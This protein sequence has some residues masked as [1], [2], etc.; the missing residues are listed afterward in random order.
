VAGI[1]GNRRLKMTLLGLVGVFVLGYGALVVWEYR[2]RRVTHADDAAAG[3]GLRLLGTVPPAGARVRAY[4]NGVDPQRAFAEAID[5]AHAAVRKPVRPACPHRPGHERRGRRRKDVAR[6]SPGHQSD[7][8]WVHDT[9]RG[10]GCARPVRPQP[11]R[12]AGE[13]WSVRSAPRAGGRLGGRSLHSGPGPVG[14]PG[15]RLGPGNP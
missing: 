10:R 3:L 7:P 4:R 8:G 6:R 9:A 12:P 5:P 11:L 1:Q 15:R 2:T 13:P 14:P